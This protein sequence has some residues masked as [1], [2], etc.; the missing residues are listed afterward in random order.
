[1]AL[2]RPSLV[3]LDVGHG[4]AAVVCAL[5]ATVVVDTGRAADLLEFLSAEG[6]RHVDLVLIS[7]ADADHLGGLVGLLASGVALSRVVLNGDALKDTKI[8]GDVLFELQS[9]HEEDTIAFEVG[10]SRGTQPFDFDELSLEVVAPSQELAAR[11]VG[12]QTVDGELIRSNTLSAVVRVVFAGR[13]VALLPGDLDALG[14]SEFQ[15]WGSAQELTADVLVYPH[16]GGRSGGDDEGLA[17]GLAGAVDPDMVAFSIGRDH[18]GNPRPEIVDALRRRLP[19]VRVACTQLSTACAM[20]VSAPVA[21]R[22]L[23]PIHARGRSKASCCAGS[24]VL[25]LADETEV[26]PDRA[27]HGA[28]ID[29]HA[30]N[31]LCRR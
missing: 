25:R 28:F 31:A 4:S 7:H 11:G 5:E 15:R 18:Y 3:V 19:T 26:S 6:I 14:F 16:H 9:R 24:I 8:W 30:P 29:A 27:A 10:L 21:T 1:M 22:H 17:E 23:A 20:A 12:G 13:P 2:D